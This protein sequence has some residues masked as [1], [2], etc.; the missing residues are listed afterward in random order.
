MGP[1]PGMSLLLQKWLLA[2]AEG[3]V[4]QEQRTHS[5]GTEIPLPPPTPGPHVQGLVGNPFPLPRPWYMTSPHP[6]PHLSLL[7][8]FAVLSWAVCHGGGFSICL[9]LPRPVQDTHCQ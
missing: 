2:D 8:V 4:R 5:S 1:C 7:P 6:H 9:P 3:T